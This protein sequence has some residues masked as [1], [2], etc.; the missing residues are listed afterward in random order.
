[1][2]GPVEIY[3]SKPDADVENRTQIRVNSSRNLTITLREQEPLDPH[4]AVSDLAPLE[5]TAEHDEVFTVSATV[6]NTGDLSAEKTVELR[7]DNETV[8][9]TTVELDAGNNTTVEFEVDASEID[10]GEYT[11]SVWTEDEEVEGTLTVEQAPVNFELSNPDPSNP[12]V[13]QGETFDMSVEVTNTGAQTATK[14]IWLAINGS[15]VTG[16]NVTLNADQSDTITFENLSADYEPGEYGIHV[17]VEGQGAEGDV[18][19][20][21]TVQGPT[22][23]VVGDDPAKDLN[24]DGLYEDVNGDGKFDL[25]DVQALYANFDND[26]VQNNVD[27]FDFNDDG[28]VNLNDVQALYFEYRN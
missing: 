6:E 17:A 4:F 19:A 10:P 9:N 18:S 16:Q 21:L 25:V 11:H 15:F 2:N 26:V 5:Y 8:A 14:E 20:T 23:I 28:E 3:A 24:G 12:T 7:L 27:L 22:P 1:V 13:D